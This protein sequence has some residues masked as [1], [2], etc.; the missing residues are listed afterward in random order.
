VSAARL[1]QRLGTPARAAGILADALD[2]IEENDGGVD[3]ATAKSVAQD[4]RRLGFEVPE[5]RACLSC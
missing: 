1:H 3:L 5:R 2:R 4:Y